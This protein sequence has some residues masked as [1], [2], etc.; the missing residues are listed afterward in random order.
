MKLSKDALGDVMKFLASSVVE[1]ELEECEGYDERNI[2]LSNLKE[3]TLSSE[4]TEILKSFN[5]KYDKLKILHLYQLHG[6]NDFLHQFLKNNGTIEELNLYMTDS[7]CFFCDDALSANLNLH[8]KSIFISHKSNNELQ[9]INLDNIEKF[10]IA[11]GD[12][13]EIISLINSANLLLLLRTWNRLKALK[14]LYFFSTDPF[15]D[16]C[17]ETLNSPLKNNSTLEELELHSLAPYPFSIEDIRPFLD[18]AKNLKSIAVWHLRKDVAEYCEQLK[19]LKSISYVTTDEDCQS[20]LKSKN[21]T[22]AKLRFN[23][24]LI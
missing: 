13:L 17:D 24:Y 4:S 5:L 3:L 8:L 18:A 22:N 1:L 2:E 19:N 15:F 11:Q 14:R 10:L 9:A 21:G 12:R 7:S 20:Y 23:Q 16:Y 6:S